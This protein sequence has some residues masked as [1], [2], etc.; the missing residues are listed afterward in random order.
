MLKPASDEG[1]L[2]TMHPAELKIPMVAPT[3]LGRIAAQLLKEPVERT[4]THYVE[5]PER[6][7]ASDVGAAFSK[8]LGRPVRTV[9]TMRDQWEE[10]YRELGFSE[11]A[12]HSYARMTAVSVDGDYDM[13]D[14]PIRGCVKL[15]SHIEHLVKTAF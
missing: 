1:V 12:A 14:A 8:A 15:E 10:A 11:P 9:V 5:G 7:S 4:G 13:P 3:D 2:P 6:Y